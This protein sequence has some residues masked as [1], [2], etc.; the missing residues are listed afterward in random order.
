MATGL[1][2][3]YPRLVLA[4]ASPRR[5][6]ILA[7]AG[8]EFTVRA[9]D[10]DERRLPG[11]F[12]AQ[13][14]RRLA[15]EKA[16]KTYRMIQASQVQVQLR[17]LPVLGADTIV[18]MDDRI[19]GKPASEV[20][21]AEMLSQLAGKTHLVLTGVSICYPSGGDTPVVDT[22]VSATL[23]SFRSL[24]TAQI[25]D[26]V[27]S[28]EPLDKAGAYGIQGLA[29]KFVERIEGC[30]FNVVGLPIS[31]V[32]QMLEQRTVLWPAGTTPA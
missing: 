21:A 15:A 6:E 23:V 8:L 14:A 4:S 17:R 20:E 9:A 2:T 18:T 26:Y 7:S 12:P 27:R 1:P 19:M 32:C 3:F 28:Q 22:E 30:Y 29:C 24:S 11:E 25:A 31:L 10:I 16:L 5:K 13:M